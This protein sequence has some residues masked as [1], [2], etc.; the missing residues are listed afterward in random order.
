MIDE[1]FIPTRLCCGQ[2]HF[3]PICPDGKVMCCLCFCC[4]DISDLHVDLAT[5]KP[6]DVCK[7]CAHREE[8]RMG[9]PAEKQK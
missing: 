6:E 7:E 1:P 5:G 9:V 2:K 8:V 3:G 4:F